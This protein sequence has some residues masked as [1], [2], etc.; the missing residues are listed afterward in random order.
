MAQLNPLPSHP[1]AR[2]P[3]V[4]ARADSLLLKE[5]AL[6]A[7]WFLLVPAACGA[8]AV[9]ILAGSPASATD[10]TLETL[11]AWLRDQA[12]LVWLGVFLLTSALLRYWRPHLPPRHVWSTQAKPAAAPR[13]GE[14]LRVVALVA[15]SIA[16]ALMTRAWLVELRKVRSSSMMP[17]LTPGDLML[18]RKWGFAT[19][20][21]RA[22][23]LPERGQPI[24]FE[25]PDPNVRELEPALFKRVV[26]LPGDVLTVERGQPVINGWRVPRCNVGLTSLALPTLN[27]PLGGALVVEWLGNATYLTLSEL[28]AS[29]PMQGPYTVKSGEI[30]VLGDNRNN[31]SDSRSW[32]GGKGG[33]VPLDDVLGSPTWT[34]FNGL[35]HTELRLQRV[36]LPVLPAGSSELAAAFARC[37]AQKPA[38]TLP[39]AAKKP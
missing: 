2:P 35:G 28:A 5:R 32:F 22:A 23:P 38:Q 12:V 10:P 36:A 18:V 25:T 15:A 29:D 4:T 26:G 19:N 27:A 6:G 14:L 9:W 37:L 16:L 1:S 3:A 24:L 17:T 11:D 33:G 7:F 20:P 39:P 34:L 8:L 13:E 30:W 21:L 31:S